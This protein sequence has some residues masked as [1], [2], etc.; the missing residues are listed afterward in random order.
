MEKAIRNVTYTYRSNIYPKMK[1]KHAKKHD[2]LTFYYIFSTESVIK[3]LYFI[4]QAT[5]THIKLKKTTKKILN[6]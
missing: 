1:G 2:L 6:K 5:T 4:T 3:Y